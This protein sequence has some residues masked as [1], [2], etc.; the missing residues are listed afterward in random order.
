MLTANVAQGVMRRRER[1]QNVCLDFETNIAVCGTLEI[2]LA[3][4][5]VGRAEP[6]K[7]ARFEGLRVVN[8]NADIGMLGARLLLR[9]IAGDAA[10]G[11]ALRRRH[12]RGDLV[13][14]TLED[15]RFAINENGVVMAFTHRPPYNE[16]PTPN[17]PAVVFP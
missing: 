12:P 17:R 9:L 1:P 6:V 15:D 5:D 16:V 3:Q 14:V 2:S 13:G 7:H 11:S 4:A 10:S 8:Q